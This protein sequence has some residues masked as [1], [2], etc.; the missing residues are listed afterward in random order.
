[1]ELIV[2]LRRRISFPV[3]YDKGFHGFLIKSQNVLT[4]LTLT[5]VMSKYIY[6]FFAEYDMLNNAVF[7]ITVEVR[8]INLFQYSDYLEVF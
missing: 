8:E 1:M 7:N 2:L 5:A 4:K 3:S 6:T